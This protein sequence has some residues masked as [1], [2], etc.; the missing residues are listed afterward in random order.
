MKRHKLSGSGS[1]RLFRATAGRHHR[2][3][4]ISAVPM[5]RGGI[6]L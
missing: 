2:K 1:R 4:G 5:V 3:N 6:R